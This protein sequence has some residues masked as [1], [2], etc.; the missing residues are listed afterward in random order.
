[1]K[2]YRMREL[3][4]DQMEESFK[5]DFTYGSNLGLESEFLTNDY[6]EL[7]SRPKEYMSLLMTK[8]EL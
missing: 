2:S 5:K 8:G 4:T 7:K 1:M 3:L 6:T